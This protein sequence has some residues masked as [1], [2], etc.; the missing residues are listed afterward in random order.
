MESS[1][2]SY[3]I[4][5]NLLMLFN[6]I[7]KR[8][9]WPWRKP[10]PLF[11]KRASPNDGVQCLPWGPGDRELSSPIITHKPSRGGK[12]HKT[13]AVIMDTSCHPFLLLHPVNQP[14]RMSQSDGAQNNCIRLY[15]RQHC[16]WSMLTSVFARQGRTSKAKD[17]EDLVFMGVLMY[18]CMF[19]K[20]EDG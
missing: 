20:E 4:N 6:T 11:I 15:R 10:A 13:P 17:R 7:I 18:V 9:R 16:S 12:P 1:I 2:S 5:T 14:V 3:C 8:V 19:Q